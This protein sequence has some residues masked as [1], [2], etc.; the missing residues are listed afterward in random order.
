[1]L[2]QTAVAHFNYSW[3]ELCEISPHWRDDVIAKRESWNNYTDALCKDGEITLKQYENWSN[4]FWHTI[5]PQFF[6]FNTMKFVLLA[7]IAIL[8]YNSNDARFFVSDQLNNVSDIIRPE[9]QANFR[10]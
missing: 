9:P 10:F 7:V 2:K 6:T 1:M 3:N 8:L 4:P 5:R